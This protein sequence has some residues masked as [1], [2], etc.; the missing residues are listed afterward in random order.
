MTAND[1]EKTTYIIPINMVLSPNKQCVLVDI[2]H[3]YGRL[4]FDELATLL[5][6]SLDRL[7]ALLKREDY[8]NE[9]EATKLVQYFCIC[10]GE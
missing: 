10:C 2:L 6:I 7:K 5:C 9:D 3:K 8:F 4:E 1:I